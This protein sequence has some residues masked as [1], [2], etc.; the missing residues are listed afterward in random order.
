MTK[1]KRF[2]ELI[3]RDRIF[4]RPSC[5][6]AMSAKILEAN[7]FEAVG[8]SGYAVSVSRL[9][10]P[11]SGQVTLTESVRM[12]RYICQ[13]VDLP[14]M[15]D[16]DTGYGNA[17]NVM[18]TVEEMIGAGAAALFIEDQVEPKRC[19]HV[20]G[21]QIIPVEE[22]VG[23]YR[24]ADRVR[25]ELDADFVLMARTDARGAVGGGFDEALNRAKAYVDAGVDLVFPEGL[26]SAEEIH[27]F[28]EELP[29]PISYNRTGVSPMLSLRELDRLGVR[30]VA[31]ASGMIV[32]P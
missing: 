15:V 24:A 18:R 29:V 25:R 30:M 10:K 14:V 21:K 16:A 3:D 1:S 7:G 13:S 26:L 8:L 32:D 11:D 27:R 6:D 19:G 20:S 31:N 5:F 2:R 22:A 4:V 9:G 12:A 28:T 17:I 23:K